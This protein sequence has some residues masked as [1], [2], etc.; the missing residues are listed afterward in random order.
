MK[1]AP[2]TQDVYN[3]FTLVYNFNLKTNNIPM[4]KFGDGM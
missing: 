1:T 4:V 2:H 3:A